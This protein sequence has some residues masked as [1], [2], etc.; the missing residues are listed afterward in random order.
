[1]ETMFELPDNDLEKDVRESKMWK[2]QTELQIKINNK[3]RVVRFNEYTQTYQVDTL[4]GG[5]Q[6]SIKDIIKMEPKKYNYKKQKR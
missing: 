5:K 4:E 3:Y 1:M 6:Y 2:N